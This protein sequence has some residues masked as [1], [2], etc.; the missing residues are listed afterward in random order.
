MIRHFSL[1]ALLFIVTVST[2]AGLP[3]SDSQGKAL[4]SLAPMLEKATPAVVNINTSSKVRI[5]NN[6]LLDDPFFRHFFDVPEQ[7]RERTNQSLGSGVIVDAKKG[8]ILTNNHVIHKADE[9]QVTLRDGRSFQAKLVGTDPET[10]VA[11][12]QIDAKRLTALKF[13]NS[14]R[15]RVGDFAVAIGNPFGL[16]Q[17]VTSG[18]ISALGRSGLGIEGY[19]DFIQTDASIN[20]GNSGGAL[21]SLTGKLI[22]INTAIFSQSGGNI[23]IGFA[24][25]INMARDIMGQLIKHGKVRRGVLGIQAQ[26]LTPELAQAFDIDKRHHRGAV[27]T[28]IAKDS[29]AQKAGLKVGDIIVEANRRAVISSANVRNIVGLLRV[30]EKV[31]FKVLRNSKALIL[32]AVVSEQK[33]QWVDGGTF[34]KRLAGAAIS[35]I[36]SGHPYY[37]HIE[38]LVILAIAPGSPAAGVGLRKG[39]VITS[40]NKQRIKALGDM[41]SAVKRSKRLLLNVRRGNGAFFVIID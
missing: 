31:R 1:I 15:L 21:V 17:T 13:A 7:P 30:G 19:E 20:P 14:D 33:Q 37:G 5:Q 40:V 23:G 12:I 16:G 35:N 28:S 25:P 6:P 11:V 26:D 36:E 38:G 24:I 22:G 2:H 3:M 8:Y 29:A 39:D 9:I 41:K 10:D 32:S 34:S 27:I 4:P 18:I